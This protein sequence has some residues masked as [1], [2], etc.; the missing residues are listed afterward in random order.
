[1]LVTVED[2]SREVEFES[3]DI[4][5]QVAQKGTSFGNG[6]SLSAGP[7]SSPDERKG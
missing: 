6:I 7:V 1:M 3:S 2:R 4:L 5:P